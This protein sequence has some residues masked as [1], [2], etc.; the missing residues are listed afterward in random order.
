[1]LRVETDFIMGNIYV[2]FILL[3]L[4]N[5][6]AVFAQISKMLVFFVRDQAWKVQ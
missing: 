6:C 4:K 1:M 3:L 5:S 2:C